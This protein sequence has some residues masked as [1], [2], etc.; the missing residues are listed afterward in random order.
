MNSEVKNI[1]ISVII[2]NYNTRELLINCLDSLHVNVTGVTYEIIVVDNASVDESVEAVNKKYPFVKTI[3]SPVN[4]G[5]GRANNL[6][7]KEAVGKYLLLLNSDTILIEDSISKMCNFF[8]ENEEKLKIGSLGCT[9]IDE[10]NNI[11]NSGGGFPRIKYDYKEYFFQI[12]SRVFKMKFEGSDEYD[13]TLPYFDINYVIGADIMMK[14]DVFNALGGFDD[15]FF[16]YYEEADLQYRLRKKLKLN[17]YIYTQ[18]KIIHL[19]GGSDSSVQ[20][21]SNRKRIMIQESRN[22]YYK[23]NDTLYYPIYLI[24]DMIFNVKTIFKRGYTYKENLEYVSK[25]IKSY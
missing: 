25:N 17:C 11:M 9:L 22:Y 1:E 7:A 8:T 19:E 15:K 13:F 6:G 21:V 23:K 24:T 16:M 18:T 14:R 4:L 5:F 20:K 10:N 2:V 12:L 3:P